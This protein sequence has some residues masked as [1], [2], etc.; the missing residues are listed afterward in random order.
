MIFLNV[1]SFSGFGN[2]TLNNISNLFKIYE[3]EQINRANSVWGII[4]IIDF[5]WSFSY[6]LW[7]KKEK[8]SH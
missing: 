6:T 7:P 2:I 8:D 4:L 1:S 5:I 3:D